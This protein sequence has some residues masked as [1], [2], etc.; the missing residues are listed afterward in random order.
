MFFCTSRGPEKR[1]IFD[2]SPLL[3]NVVPRAMAV[4]LEHML[5][6]ASIEGNPTSQTGFGL[7]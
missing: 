4:F 3:Y 6:A 2:E 1:A 7:T 5:D